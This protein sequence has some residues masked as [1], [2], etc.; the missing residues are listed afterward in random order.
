MKIGIA[1]TGGIV[2]RCLITLQKLKGLH[3]SAICARAKS[4]AKAQALAKA[5]GIDRVYV[6]YE[7]MLADENVDFVY[8]GV[9]NSVHYAYAK[10]ALEAGKHVICEKP[11]TS[12]IEETKALASLAIEKKLFFFEAITLLYSPNYLFMKENLHRIGQIRIVQ[13]DYFQYSSRYDQFLQG[14]V[15]P[16]FDP[17]LSG[18]AL[19]DINIYNLHMVV[20]LFGKPGRVRY[21]ANIGFNGIDTSG[22]ALLEY[23]GFVAACS[24]AKDSQSVS[25]VLVQGEKG[26]IRLEGAPNVCGTVEVVV[27]ADRQRYNGERHEERMADEFIAFEKMYKEQDFEKCYA[28]LRHSETVMEVATAARKDA[29]IVF[30]ADAEK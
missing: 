13:A 11:L 23:D 17:A 8:I 2:E 3:C 15:L 10:Q 20:G 9:V 7:A 18:G 12:R 24:G 5:Y 29:G 1:G 4:V 26:Y 21:S 28:Q 27:G 19:Y 14:Q 30:P 25:G 16:A 6:D 22:I